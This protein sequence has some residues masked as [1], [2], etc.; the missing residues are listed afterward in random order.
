M[1][2]NIYLLYTTVYKHTDTHI[3]KCQTNLSR[4]IQCEGNNVDKHTN[5]VCKAEK[6]LQGHVDVTN[7]L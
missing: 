4:H 2:P 6:E 3:L 7:L 1:W 5:S